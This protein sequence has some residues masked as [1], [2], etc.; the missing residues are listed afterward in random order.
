M[1]LLPFL[2]LAATWVHEG[3]RPTFTVSR[4]GEITTSGAGHHPNWLH[5]GLEYE[6]FRLQF[7]YKLD[8]WAEA[9][10]IFRA[11]RLGRPIHSGIALQLAHD[12]HNEVTPHITGAI[13]GLRPPLTRV[14]G[15]FG[16][17]HHID[18]VMRGDLLIARLDDVEIQNARITDKPRRGFIGFPDLGYRYSVKNVSIEDLGGPSRF[19]A[20]LEGDGIREWKLRGGGE[21]SIADGVVKGSNGHGILYAPQSFRNFEL[22]V[23]VR[24]HNRVNAGIFLRGS[25][26]PGLPRGFEVQIYNVPDAVYPTGSVYNIERSR[27]AADYDDEWVFMEILVRETHCRVRINGDVVAETDKLPAPRPGQV[28]LQIHLENA[29]VEFRDLRVRPM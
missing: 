13:V 12:F 23:L 19:V 5:T 26:Q 18:L 1:Q 14:A 2:L 8:Q 10:V 6:D 25:S 11:P 7:D 27:I 29:S 24:G 3:P 4:A 15:D 22:T 21:W 20:L 17:W 16:K 28:G 9:A